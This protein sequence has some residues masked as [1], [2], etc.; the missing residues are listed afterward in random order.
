MGLIDFNNVM[1]L[2]IGSCV[3]IAV[4]SIVV[5]Y[6]TKQFIKEKLGQKNGQ[7][8]EKSLEKALEENKEG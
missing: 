8:K 7:E 6:I 4:F 3:I 5:Y 2:I 1:T